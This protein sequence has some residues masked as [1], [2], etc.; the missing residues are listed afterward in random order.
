MLKLALTTTVDNRYVGYGS[1]LDN[2]HRELRR[3]RSARIL[4]EPDGADIEVHLGQPYP[5]FARSW[6]R[7]SKSPPIRGI[8][9]MFEA[10]IL[11]GGWAEAINAEFDFCIV[12]SLWCADIF[13]NC[14]VRLPIYVVPL[15]VDPTVFAPP[16]QRERHDDFFVLWQGN[17]VGDRK[18]GDILQEVFEEIAGADWKLIQKTNPSYSKFLT[19]VILPWFGQHQKKLFHKHMRPDELLWLYDNCDVAVYPTR[20]EGFGL[21][22]LEQAAAGL[23]VILSRS[24]G[25]LEFCDSGAFKTLECDKIKIEFAGAVQ[26]MDDPNRDEIARHLI[27]CY[28][29][30]EE[31][32]AFGLRASEIIR[33]DWTWQRTAKVFLEVVEMELSKTTTEVRD[34][35]LAPAI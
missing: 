28:E 8:F 2:L 3:S 30:R 11:P 33:R 9:T 18:G 20:G 26:E 16:L 22:P 7:S 1:V 14:G 29:H 6:R 12:P 31:A 34:A 35:E 32:R 21:I 19:T 25:C 24:S 10:P 27:W 23:P 4:H 5:M 13:A 15:G 17:T